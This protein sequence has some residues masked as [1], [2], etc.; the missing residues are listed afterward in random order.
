VASVLS[1]WQ[2]NYNILNLSI[3][4]L[5]INTI[6]PITVSVENIKEDKYHQTFT[7]NC[8]IDYNSSGEIIDNN[9]RTYTRTFTGL[10]TTDYLICRSDNEWF[11]DN[12]KYN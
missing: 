2:E 8:V 7:G 3:S 1:Y 9:Y 4:S 12:I 10:S 6:L 11:Y 5:S